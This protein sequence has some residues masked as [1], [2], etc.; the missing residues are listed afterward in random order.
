MRPS[1]PVKNSSGSVRG[2]H[3]NISSVC[4]SNFCDIGLTVDLRTGRVIVFRHR[5][6]H[7]GAAVNRARNMIWTDCLRQ[8]SRD[9]PLYP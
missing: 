8:Q 6:S 7:Q 5:Q 9:A 4:G 1:T 2:R 3:P